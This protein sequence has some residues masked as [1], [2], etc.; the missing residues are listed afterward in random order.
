MHNTKKKTMSKKQKKTQSQ[1]KQY[2]K[3]SRNMRRK[4]VK[5]TQ[6][7][8]NHSGGAWYNRINPWS[9]YRSSGNLTHNMS[10]KNL[11]NMREINENKMMPYIK[12]SIKDSELFKKL[13][14]ELY[15]KYNLLE[16]IK[17]EYIPMAGNF[18][19]GNSM[20]AENNHFNC[21]INLNDKIIFNLD[22]N[23]TTIHENIGHSVRKPKDVYYI[24][25]NFNNNGNQKYN[26]E[27]KKINEEFQ[28]E[29]EE[30]IINYIKT[31]EKI[32][33]IFTK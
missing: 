4:N 3:R 15:E 23:K 29:F 8:K 9:K 7:K 5:K 24:S 32:Y 16:W 31:N 20:A 6:T 14:K 2:R 21:S 25:Y 18:G 11:S 28:D 10:E 12:D 26:I 17:N 1:T 19:E 13:Q 33:N 27:L 30:K 22:I